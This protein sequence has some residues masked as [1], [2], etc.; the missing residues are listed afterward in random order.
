MTSPTGTATPAAPHCPAAATCWDL[1]QETT[2]TS[3]TTSPATEQL[4]GERGP[5]GPEYL[6]HGGTNYD[7]R[8]VCGTLTIWGGLI[9]KYRG[10]V[11]T[12]DSGGHIQSGYAKDYHYDT[13]VTARTPPAFPLTGTYQEVAWSE[14]WDA[15][16]PF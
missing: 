2:S 14:T 5:D 3:W 6:H 11:G 12:L 13:R 15:S 4:E 1:S 16:A 10:A 7:T 9:Q 8:S